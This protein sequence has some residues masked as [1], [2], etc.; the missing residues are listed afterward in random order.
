MK[1][2]AFSDTGGIYITAEGT[3][4]VLIVFASFPD[5]STPHPYWQRHQPPLLMQQFIDPDTL[6][7]SSS[8]FNLT[9]YFRQMSLGALNLV[10]R[11]I[12]IESTHSQEE[13]RDGAYGR[14]NRHLLQEQ[15]D[16]LIDF[17]DYDQWTKVA[18]YNHVNAPDGVVDMIFMVWRTNMFEYLGEASLGYNWGGFNV[19]GKRIETGYPAYLPY[20]RGSGVTV[21][22]IYSDTPQRVMQTMVHEIGHWLLGKM[23][24]YNGDVLNDKH[25]YWGILCSNQRVASCANAYERERL[26]WIV[27]PELPRDRNVPLADFLTTGAAFKYHPPV[28]EPF[29]YF[30]F[31]NHQ[32]R[33]PFDDVTMNADDKGV[34]ILHQQSPYSEMDNFRIKPSDGSWS[35]ANP[36]TTTQ[37]FARTLPAFRKE[38][39]HTAGLSH[40]DQMQAFVEPFGQIRCGVFSAGEY[41][42]GSFNAMNP[43]FSPY[44]NPSTNTWSNQPTPLSLE[45]VSDSAG[46]L[47]LRFAATPLDAAPAKRFLGVNPMPAGLPPGTLALAWGAQWSTGQPLEPDVNFSELQRAV[48]VGSTWETVYQGSTTAWSDASL[49]YDTSGTIPVRFRARVRDTQGKFSAWSDVFFTR[50]RP[51]NGVVQHTD[52]KPSHYELR[53]NYPNPFNPTTTITFAL[54]VAENVTLVL[55]NPL[56]CTVR[57]LLLKEQYGPGVHSVLVHA[58]DLPSGV[59]LYRMITPH[60]TLTRKMCLTR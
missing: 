31:E 13:Y 44:S 26:G 7:M 12:W 3:L 53:A 60:F 40:R 28:G 54:P 25:A 19:D 8:P 55:Y 34:W 14:A 49:Y 32:R 58:H 57:T 42:S 38:S 4:R 35:W 45:V 47:T 29:E 17:S 56:G 37:C 24:P 2:V 52:T 33:S 9:N 50:S 59:Y 43:V 11:A 16:P 18:D 15:A 46:S 6:T 51:S 23:H 27:V 10:G 22:Y 30:Y 21:Q 1:T 5:D 48:G 41:F 39:P 36:F 20:P